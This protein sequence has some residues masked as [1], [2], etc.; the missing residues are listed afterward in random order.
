MLTSA[1]H[2]EAPNA[3]T[4]RRT[5]APRPLGHALDDCFSLAPVRQLKAKEPLFAEGDT[6]SN[7]YRIESGAVLI[8]KIL[9]DGFRQIVSFAF[10]GDYVG[11][12]M[13]PLYTYDAQ[14]IAPTRIR[15]LPSVALWRRAREDAAIA[16][17]IFETLSRE[18]S[19]ARRH[20]LT[21]GRLSATGRIA[22]FL[23]ALAH[24]NE[25]KSLD[26]VDIQLPVR[27]SDIADFLCL[28]VETVSRSL[29][30]LKTAHIISLRGWRQIKL[31][32][33]D[34]LERLAAGETMLDQGCHL[35]RAA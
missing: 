19:D 20:F 13:S 7:I 31:I 3:W 27:R 29:T 30:E 15:A 8:Y 18:I 33:R 12:E 23:I 26:A 17:E 6:K 2:A 4:V 14:T 11:L 22:T 16:G 28:S 35:K 25:R 24:R 32:D 10:P 1:S 5:T 34:A 21:I 9:N